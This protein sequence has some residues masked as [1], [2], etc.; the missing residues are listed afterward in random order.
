[1]LALTGRVARLESEGIEEEVEP[2]VV[3]GSA[4][5]IGASCCGPTILANEGGVDIV[6][7]VCPDLTNG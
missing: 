7:D 6:E 2:N 3:A 1:M 4:S 5:L